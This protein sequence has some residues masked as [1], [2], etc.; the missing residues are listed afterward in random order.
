[1]DEVTSS[2][3]GLF[4]VPQYRFLG[5]H[6]A[7]LSYQ[8]CR[9]PR[10]SSYYKNLR[11]TKFRLPP[12]LYKVIS[13]LFSNKAITLNTFPVLVFKKKAKKRNQ[14]S[15][16]FTSPC[17]FLRKHSNPRFCWT[18]VNST[19]WGACAAPNWG[20]GK[21]GRL[22]CGNVVGMSWE[23]TRDLLVTKEHHVPEMAPTVLWARS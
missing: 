19:L 4:A 8:L 6:K 12:F 9:V 13:I 20:R 16:A 22:V 2:T 17:L 1:M 18:Q 14:L 5:S 3:L 10:V 7:W 23:H 11:A 21:R 15:F